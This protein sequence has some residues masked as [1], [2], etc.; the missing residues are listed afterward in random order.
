MS[1]TVSEAGER[2]ALEPGRVGSAGVDADAVAGAAVGG[3]RPARPRARWCRCRRRGRAPRASSG[4]V[5][6][7]RRTRPVGL[8][9]SKTC[10]TS[11]LSSATAVSVEPTSSDEPDGAS[12]SC[13]ARPGRRGAASRAGRRR[14]ASPLRPVDLPAD[15]VVGPLV[16]QRPAP[17]PHRGPAVAEDR[18]RS[19]RA[20]SN[21]GRA[22]P[23]GH[24][25]AP[26][27]EVQGARGDRV[28]PLVG[29]AQRQQAGS[30]ARP[31]RG[32]VEVALVH[33]VRCCSRRA[34]YGAASRA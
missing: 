15:Q 18:P 14:P 22:D 10:P 5:A 16:D 28:E 21:G 13:A 26:H 6:R 32:Q 9:D 20:P 7:I 24:R 34:P 3:V 4:M 1:A 11:S 12:A 30:A 8:G 23:P 17:A 27:G 25:V 33:G 31:R 2:A 19:R 29:V